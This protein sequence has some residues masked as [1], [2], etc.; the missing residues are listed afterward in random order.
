MMVALTVEADG[1]KLYQLLDKFS[2]Q[3]GASYSLVRKNGKFVLRIKTDDFG[4]F[5][6]RLNLIKDSK[7][8]I[9][10]IVG[11][12][13]I[14][15]AKVDHTPTNVDALIGKQTMTLSDVTPIEGCLIKIFGEQ[16]FCRSDGERVIKKGTFVRVLGVEGV[17]LIVE[18]I[19][20][21]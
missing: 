7:Y 1:F 21:G 8:H 4:E 20:E 15:R 14:R 11:N 2:Q 19:Q 17:S 18:P 5:I 9:E 13:N 16:W 12:P 6:R 10:E 3:T